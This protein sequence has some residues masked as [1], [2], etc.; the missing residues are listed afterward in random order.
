MKQRDPASGPLSPPAGAR[1]R[2]ARA[3]AVLLLPAVVWLLV[4]C[5][6]LYP[7]QT[8]IP[9]EGREACLEFMDR[10]GEEIEEEGVG[11]AAAFPVPGF[12]Y[13][14]TNRYLAALKDR[15]ADDSEKRA[16][17]DGMAAL[18]LE[19]LQSEIAALP[20]RAVAGLPPGRAGS[21]KALLK[22]AASCSRSLRNTDMDWGNFYERL[23]ANVEV[24][25]E[26]SFAM[27]VFGLYPL[28]YL[29]EKIVTARVR[30]RFRTL[31][32]TP[33]EKLPIEGSLMSYGPG[34]APSLT[35]A[36]VTRIL[37]RASA[38]ALKT[39]LPAGKD[40]RILKTQKRGSPNA[41]EMPLPVGR[42]ARL[43]VAQFAPIF[44]QDT[45]APYDESGRVAWGPEG[46]TVDTKAPT[47]YHYFTHTFLKGSP[48][49][50]INY[51][52]WYPRRAGPNSPSI[53]Q[54]KLDGLTVR[55]S[56]DGEGRV[57]MVDI[58]N[59]CGCYHLFLPNR[60]MV[61]GVIASSWPENP[62]APQWLPEIPSDRRLAIRVMSGWHQVVGISTIGGNILSNI[63]EL[64]PYTVLESLP[65][66]DGG[67]ESM[68]DERG[69]AKGSERVERYLFFPMGIPSVGSMRQ[70][71]HHAIAL[72]GRVH[73]D[74]PYLFEK[75]FLF[76]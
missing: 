12:P 70:R 25:D 72:T 43:L 45:V 57:F 41:P 28:A 58:M 18:S 26:Y 50:Q 4:G 62:Y 65:R 23:A 10:L 29:P 55:V 42:D 51:V 8:R 40:A 54:G 33:P 66:P 60:S 34:A 59:N 7:P 14:R 75:N 71:G 63:C 68:F 27:R 21:R 9:A 38:N 11:N 20:E 49:L 16:W 52:I 17:V 22:Q 2:G 32:A 44:I 13:L 35:G 69:I 61:A 24:P 5:A 19:A 37:K 67:H 53:E 46:L 1:N 30:E 36:E 48:A 76:K 39:P 15:L 64:V 47:I 3:L 74:D 56:L 73:F 6:V 31:L